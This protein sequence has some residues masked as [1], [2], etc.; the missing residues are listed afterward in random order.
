MKD[1]RIEIIKLLKY[2][3]YFLGVPL[4]F[5]AVIIFAASSVVNLDAYTVD[6]I[7]QGAIPQISKAYYYPIWVALALFLIMVGAHIAIALTVKNSRIKTFSMTAVVLVVMLIPLVTIDGVYKSKISKIQEANQSIDFKNYEK[8]LGYVRP[9]SSKAG[10]RSYVSEFQKKLTLFEHEFNLGKNAQNESNMTGA[11]GNQPLTYYDFG[12]DYDGDGEV[13]PAMGPNKNDA[14]IIDVK[15]QDGNYN[16]KGDLVKGKKKPWLRFEWNGEVY[17]D[18]DVEVSKNGNRYRYIRKSFVP[19]WKNGKYGY[20]LYYQNGELAD[21][22]VYSAEVA[23]NILEQYYAAKEVVDNREA[24]NRDELIGNAYQRRKDDYDVKGLTSLYER[25][26]GR[27]LDKY[28]LNDEKL[29]KVIGILVA[30]VGQLKLPQDLVDIL[31]TGGGSNLIEEIK[32]GVEFKKIPEL[33][34]SLLNQFKSP[35]MSVLEKLKLENVKLTIKKELNPNNPTNTKPQLRIIMEDP[36]NNWNVDTFLDETMTLGKLNEG[37]NKLLHNVLKGVGI[38][39][40]LVST[41]T[42]LVGGKLPIEF[43]SKYE[44]ATGKYINIPGTLKKIVKMVYAYRSPVLK[45]LTDYYVDPEASEDVQQLQKSYAQ[46]DAAMEEGGVRGFQKGS[47]LIPGS[48]FIAGNKVGAGST[49]KPSVA[50]LKDV[51][52]FKAELQLLP[53][54]YPMIVLREMLMIFISI[55]L[56]ATFLSC[57]FAQEEKKWINAI[58]NSK[59]KKADKTDNTETEAEVTAEPFT[60]GGTNG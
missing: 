19:Q 56:L 34:P 53:K 27:V 6:K 12:I 2:G 10:V 21:G 13:K 33:L 9:R 23:L 42:G 54:M 38:P 8:H 32:K 59:S 24:L 55:A 31:N 37:V 25:E 35:I 17:E 39:D 30:T 1:K 18:R 60:T 3:I 51:R 5:L 44:M 49:D 22:Y 4:F 40:S 57:I 14:E 43:Y 50:G 7:K 20:A 46:M 28:T 52:L 36:A 58:I 47:T 48:S 16:K 26:T 11:F 41:L 29:D 45:P 15:P